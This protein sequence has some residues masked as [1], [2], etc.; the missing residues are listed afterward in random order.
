[1]F[2]QLAIAL[3][4]F[5]PLP[6]QAQPKP[7]PIL[8]EVFPEPIRFSRGGQNR[9]W[10]F[11]GGYPDGVNI[12]ISNDFTKDVLVG[13][14]YKVEYALSTDI[15]SVVVNGSIGCN[16]KKLYLGTG[17]AYNSQDRPVQRGLYLNKIFDAPSSLISRYCPNP[18]K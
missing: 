2:K 10:E 1:M 6:L 18:T 9:F 11:I 17:D 16:I 14:D 8:P 7:R 15:R 12:Y 5:L 13:F 3:A 4:L